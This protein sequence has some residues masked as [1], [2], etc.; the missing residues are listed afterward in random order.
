VTLTPTKPPDQDL[1][2]DPAELLIKEARQQSRR[3]R[4]VN[5]LLVVV[6]IAAATLVITDGGNRSPSRVPT[7]PPSPGSGS[8]TT[9][10]SNVGVAVPGGQSVL[11]LWPVGG[12]TSWVDTENEAALSHGGQGIEWTGNGGRTWHDVTPSGDSYGVGNRFI[13]NFFALT[14]TRAWL[15][16]G[17][18]EPERSN[19]TALMTTSDSG[20]RWVRV[21]SLPLGGC[22]LSFITMR[23]GVCTSAPGAMNSAPIEVSATFNGG[24]SWTRIFDNFAGFTG[25]SGS[26]DGGVPYE[27]D[28]D[29]TVSP[30]HTVWAEGWCN[31]TQ[32]FLYR[33]TDNGRHWVSAV[34]IPPTPL[35]GG[36]SEF[37][38]PV[39]LAGRHGAVAFQEANF[40]MIDV[41][42]NGGATFRPVYPPGTERPWTIDVVTPVM[43]RLAWRNEI[44]GTN[45]GGASWFAVMGNA[46]A[47]PSVRWS[48]RW[49]NGAPSSL[50]F[51]SSSFGWLDW[52]TGGGE[53]VMTT[54]DG[55]RIWNLVAVPGTRKVSAT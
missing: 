29:F 46:F 22:S 55:G 45:N 6:M 48:Q 23:D 8:A 50:N 38:G 16:L 28:K 52:G 51:T 14:S 4:F 25:G 34:V 21:G 37:I 24:R 5:G 13:G 1:L 40:S 17:T 35:V 36:G 2:S 54:R 53:T 44:L 31:A 9:N 41:T 32:S 33:S 26:P 12:E 39:V 7:V 49:S 11:S 19:R 30:P 42:N 47:S 18:V 43:W 20:R 15:S 27:C 3:R 10:G